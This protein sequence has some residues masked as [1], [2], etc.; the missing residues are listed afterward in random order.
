[1]IVAAVCE[2]FVYFAG[3]LFLTIFFGEGSRLY[4]TD[5]SS[6]TES[7]LTGVTDFNSVVLI[8]KGCQFK[9]LSAFK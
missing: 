9:L 2:I 1:M 7:S 5:S 8:F 3:Y 6:S 4:L